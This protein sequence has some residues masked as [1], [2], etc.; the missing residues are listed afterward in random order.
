M[1]PPNPPNP[2]QE[3]PRRKVGGTLQQYVLLAI[4]AIAGI[5]LLERSLSWVFSHFKQLRASKALDLPT[6]FS[7]AS[8][9]AVAIRWLLGRVQSAFAVIEDL[10]DRVCQLETEIK[11]DTLNDGEIK[12]ILE[13]TRAR[14]AYLEMRIDHNDARLTQQERDREFDRRRRD[15]G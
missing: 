12:K 15:G 9:V 4:A 5:I 7:L 8:G 3:S 1:T 13:E 14:Q 6:L 2:E 11:S 10:E